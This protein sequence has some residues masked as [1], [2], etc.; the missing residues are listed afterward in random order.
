MSELTSAIKRMSNVS[1]ESDYASDMELILK[2]AERAHDMEFAYESVK[3]WAHR[4]ERKI[5]AILDACEEAA[6]C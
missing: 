5:V 4:L 3:E 1:F 6:Q 2:A